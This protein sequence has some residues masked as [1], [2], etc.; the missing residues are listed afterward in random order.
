MQKMK[1]YKDYI[2]GEVIDT[3]IVSPVSIGND[4]FLKNESV[5]ME[6][7]RRLLEQAGHKSYGKVNARN[8]PDPELAAAPA[9]EGELQNDIM[10]HPLLNNQ[11][12]DGTSPNLNPE[13]PLNSEART[14]YDNARREQE[15]EKQLRLGNMPK[16]RTA[17]EPNKY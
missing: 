16:M 9:P 13:P 1:I 2:E 3:G 5:K 14:T 17:P 8:H 11:R 15:M 12:F 6:R 10:A 4:S 7:D